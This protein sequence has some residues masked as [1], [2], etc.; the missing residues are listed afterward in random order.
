MLVVGGGPAGLEAARVSAERG[1]HVVLVE[2]SGEL[3]GQWRLAGHQPTRSQVL[4]HIA[5]YA[6]ELDRLGVD[7]RA[8]VR[9]SRR[10]GAAGGRP[11]DRRRRRRPPVAG[12]QRAMRLADQLPGIELGHAPTAQDVLAGNVD[13]AGRV[14]VL[15]DVDDWRGIGTAMFLQERGCSVTIATA[16]AAVAGGLFHSAADVPAR[17]RFAVAGGEL[18]PNTVVAEWCGDAARCARRS[19][20]R[21][22]SDR[23]TGSSSPGRPSPGPTLAELD[24]GGI[25]TR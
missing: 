1:H 4:D 10:R 5:W 15:D 16:A 8:G 3:G 23:S 7:V 6:R 19:P 14:L 12:F 2:A 20:E 18:A 21:D 9:S 13:V 24:V 11:R 17:R 22:R 25:A